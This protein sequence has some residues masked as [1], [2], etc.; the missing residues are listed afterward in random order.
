VGGAAEGE[1]LSMGSRV[2]C[3]LALVVGCG[4]Y[5]SSAGDHGA[6]GDLA[7]LGG[8]TGLFEGMTHEAQ[9]LFLLGFGFLG[10][11]TDDS[12]VSG[13]CKKVLVLRP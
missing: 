13:T 9:I 7:L 8:S 12:N 5:L 1:Q 6:Y 11:G 2:L 10:H 3:S 4:K